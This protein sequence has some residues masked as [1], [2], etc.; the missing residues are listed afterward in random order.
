MKPPPP[1]EERIQLTDR[2]VSPAVLAE[3]EFPLRV[4]VRGS[5][6]T[7]AFEPNGS[8]LTIWLT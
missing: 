1:K 3:L 5:H 2:R 7:F 4:Y 6:T 8:R